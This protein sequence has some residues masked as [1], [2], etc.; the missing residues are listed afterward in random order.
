MYKCENCQTIVPP[1]T[2]AHRLV[3]DTRP[4]DYPWRKY[5]NTFKSEGKV[6]HEHDF[7]GVGYETVSEISVCPDCVKLL[8]AQN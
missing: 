8:D 3:V 5:A 6:K 7:G 1:N 2:K 4:K